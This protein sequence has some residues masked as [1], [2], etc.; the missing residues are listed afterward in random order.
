MTPEG[1]RRLV[2]EF[3]KLKY[4]ER[5]RV[6]ETV[7]WAASNGD[8]SENA[9]YIYGK[10]RLREIDSRL[11]FLGKRIEHARVIDPASGSSD[12]VGFGATVTIVDEEGIEKVYSLVGEEES[13]PN[14]GLISWTSPLAK[15]ILNGR[16]GDCFTYQTPRGS[17]EAEIVFICYKPLSFS[18]SDDES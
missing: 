11:G 5:P 2:T 7:A 4:Q 1:Y 6:V 10:R 13:D 8:R 3:E 14:H 16:V 17:R 18:F 12:R 9:D 15:A